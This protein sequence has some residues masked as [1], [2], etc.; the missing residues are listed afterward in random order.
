MTKIR[1]VDVLVI[2]GGQ[3]GLAVGYYLK[4]M[5]RDFLI[6]DRGRR[7]GETWRTRYDSLKLFTPRWFS[8]L[9]GLPLN[10]DREGYALKDEIANYLAL[11]SETFALPILHQTEVTC[12]TRVEEGWFI[13]ET[14]R[15]TMAANRI[16]VATG[17]FQNPSIPPFSKQLPGNIV[18]L[19]SSE[20][21]NPDELQAGNAIVVGGGNSGA[22]IAVELSFAGKSTAISI[23]HHVKFLPI[24]FLGKSIFHWMGKAGIYTCAADSPFG[25]WLRKQPDPIFGFELKRSIRQSLIQS[26]PRVV[27]VEGESLV[28]HDG[29]KR[30]FQNIIWATGFASDYGWIQIAG[31][32]DEGGKPLHFRGVSPIPGLYFLGLPWQRNRSS[33]LLGG[34][35]EDARYIV[36]YM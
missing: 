11:Y 30:T 33:A 10:G 27:G 1:R 28:F 6:L 22:Q 35:G 31:A 4:Q 16:I 36:H 32:R 20:Y 8:S 21:R 34:V 3:A 24:T 2:G 17:P 23:G 18:Q 12:L 15:G 5:Q 14:N 7:T 19:H 9:P 26:Y 25:K 29:R 13:V